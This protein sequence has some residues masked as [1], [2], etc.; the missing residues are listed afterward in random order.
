MFLNRI[1]AMGVAVVGITGNESRKVIA[2]LPIIL[3]VAGP[4][5]VLAADSAT[6]GNAPTYNADAGFMLSV[7][8]DKKAF[9]ATFSGLLVN[10][11][12]QSPVPIVTRTFSFSLPLSGVDPATEIPFFISGTAFSEKGANTRLIFIVNDQST[13]AV[14]PEN[15]ANTDYIQELKY[16]AGTAS[17]VRVTIILIADRDSKSG[18]QAYLNVL[19]IDTDLLNRQEKQGLLKRA[20]ELFKKR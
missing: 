5:P 1:L 8:D 6:F 19:A 2:A 11:V 12:G 7:S 13:V 4:P 20:K 10:L 18:A 15:A 14:F 17:E 9:T 16:K 3:V